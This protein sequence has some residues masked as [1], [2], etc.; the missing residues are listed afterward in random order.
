V[1]PSNYAKS[2]CTMP[3][4]YRLIGLYIILLPRA[5]QRYLSDDHASVVV[6][7]PSPDLRDVWILDRARMSEPKAA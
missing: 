5:W 7:S 3:G 6:Q 2:A 4:N 1:N